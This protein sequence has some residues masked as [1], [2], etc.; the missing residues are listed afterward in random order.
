M[1]KKTKKQSGGNRK[2][3]GT[4]KEQTAS[5][6]TS[7][8]IGLLLILIVLVFLNNNK[9]NNNREILS[10]TYENSQTNKTKPKKKQA[11]VNVIIN[12]NVKGDNDN[13][14]N[15]SFWGYMN[16][17]SH[18]RI[19]NPL[20][21]PERSYEQTYGVPIN[22]PSRGTSGGYQQVGMLYKDTIT[23]ESSTIGNNSDTSILPLYGQPTHPG[24]N[25]WNYYTTSDKY[26]SV[27]IPLNVSG[28]DCS[29][30][31]G[32]TE[33]Y[34]DDNVNIPAYNGNYKVKIYNYDK[35]KYIPYVW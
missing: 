2:S 1:V 29:G 27:K 35:P 26:H 16:R 13:P 12:N 15:I 18:E 6:L 5:N 30:D 22:I 20:L 3:V 24:S 32:C 33:I 10:E 21:P 23:D 8:L 11:P 34:D 7:I 9:T 17:K 4:V 14:N 25:K 19:N 31:Y 28:K